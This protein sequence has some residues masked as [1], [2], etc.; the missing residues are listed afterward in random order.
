MRCGIKHKERIATLTMTVAVVLV[1]FCVS[2]QANSTFSEDSGK[3]SF[4]RLSAT[5][6]GTIADSRATGVEVGGN[7]AYVSLHVDGQQVVVNVQNPYAPTV[8]STSNP[9]YGDQWSDALYFNGHLF[10]GHRWGGLNMMDGINPSAGLPVLSSQSTYYH[11]R[12]IIGLNQGGNAYIFYSEGLISSSDGGLRIYDISGGTLASLG[13][14][15]SSDTT[16]G[17]LA[18]TVDGNWVYQSDQGDRRPSGS[19]A[20]PQSLNW[21]DTSDKNN[22]VLQGNLPLPTSVANRNPNYDMVMSSDEDYLFMATGEDG[23]Q[24]IDITNKAN[25]VRVKT[26]FQAGM[27]INGL[28]LTDPT[29]LV[30]TVNSTTAGAYLL[31]EL[32]VSSPATGVTIL[33]TTNMSLKSVGDVFA[34]N[35]LLYVC[36]QDQSGIPS[37]EIWQ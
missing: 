16:G 14:Y 31:A 24:V 29:T 34:T 23:I 18:V 6:V 20:V 10:S 15:I 9:T 11:S 3:A 2:A 4:T 36:G 33:G 35:G 5:A 13:S 21:Y 27:R 12:G 30:V 8:L 25:P 7:Y 22:V 19:P 32:D 1:L 17:A 26:Y 37:L 28:V